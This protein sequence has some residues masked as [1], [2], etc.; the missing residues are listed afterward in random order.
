[1]AN[2]LPDYRQQARALIGERA[3]VF[4][5]RHHSPACACQLLTLLRDRRPAEILIEGPADFAAL[6]PALAH[7]ESRPPLAIYAYDI[8]RDGT[9]RAA[10]YPFAECSPEWVAL[11][12]A[13]E[14]G[15]PCRFVDLPYAARAGDSAPEHSLQTERHLQR[16]AHLSL[17][18]TRLGCRDQEEL[19]EHLFEIP[20]PS[21]SLSEH[22]ARILAYCELARSDYS[23]AELQADGTL[24]REAHMA[25]ELHQALNRR[26]PDAG[27]VLLVLGGF[28]ALAVQQASGLERP[29]IAVSASRD[30]GAALIPFSQPRLDRLNGYAA[31]M[32]APNWHHHLF[33]T[34]RGKPPLTS[35]QLRR[36]RAQQALSLLLRLAE[37]VRQRRPLPLPMVRDALAHAQTLAALRQRGAIAA[38]DLHD[39]VRSNFLQ[40]DEDL[41]A[42]AILSALDLLMTGSAM[43]QVPR[44]AGTVPLL[45]DFMT[46]AQ[47]CRLKLDGIEA[48]QTTL[49]LYRRESHRQT[50]RLLHA[51]LLLGIPFAIKLSGPSIAQALDLHRATER[52]QYQYTPATAAAIVEASIHGPTLDEAVREAFARQLD[53]ALASGDAR[54]A[55]GAVRWLERACQAGI[56]GDLP[57]LSSLVQQALLDDAAFPSLAQAV[58]GLHRLT[59]SETLSDSMA[60]LPMLLTRAWQR[61]LYLAQLPGA[62]G[63]ADA[64]AAGLIELRVIA[65][66]SPDLIDR[67][68]LDAALLGLADGH[69]SALVRGCAVALAHARGALDVA[70]LQTRLRGHLTGTLKAADAVAFLRGLLGATRELAWQEPVLIETLDTLLRGWDDQSFVRYLPELRLAFCELT[71][72]ETDRIAAAVSAHTGIDV[73]PTVGGDSDELAR[74]LA[75]DLAAYERLSA[76]GLGHWWTA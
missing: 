15:I 25:F 2:G 5:I 36:I 54:S 41:D 76:D 28:H 73:L 23:A 13:A 8:G 71:P 4:P 72:H 18:A 50:S 56:A 26:A 68:L 57:T 45:R 49:Q 58:V 70:A 47:R 19:W 51:G 62:S 3:I 10:Y 69:P 29:T 44:E 39:A 67:T 20:G 60:A 14:H 35:G 34:L 32:S 59:R 11:R 37:D 63:D 9:R 33:A 24:A 64:C 12:F 40:G 21:L 48:R 16:S 75:A 66:L 38:V 22:V 52:W 6:L 31:G 65:D 42:S 43:G 55:A 30:S 17:L 74:H 7:P 61:A 46:R 27:P 53:K 1:M